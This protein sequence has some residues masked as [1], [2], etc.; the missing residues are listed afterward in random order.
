VRRLTFATLPASPN[1]VLRMNASS[2]TAYAGAA[3]VPGMCWYDTDPS[4]TQGFWDH[5]PQ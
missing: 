2:A 4:R 5:C 1:P 3:P